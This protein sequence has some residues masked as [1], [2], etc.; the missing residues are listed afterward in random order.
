[1]APYKAVM[2][3]A[4]EYASSVLHPRP[5]LTNCKNSPY[6]YIYMMHIYCDV[7]IYIY[8]YIYIILK[9]ECKL[10]DSKTHIC[11]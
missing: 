5:A 10:F 7:Y 2:R 4:L 11:I 3:P 1:M 9:T 8:I 6:I